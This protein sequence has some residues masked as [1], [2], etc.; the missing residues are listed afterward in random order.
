MSKDILIATQPG[1]FHAHAVAEALRRKGER[2]LL[3][4]T[5]DFPHRATETVRFTGQTR[6]VRIAGPGLDVLDAGD[7]RVGVVWY[8]RPDYV[9]DEDALHPADVGFADL[10]CDV[11]RLSLFQVLGQHAFWV[12]DPAA[13]RQNSKLVQHHAAV[14]VG[15]R[16]PDTL[17]S[18]D[19][20]AIRAFLR[21]Q[22]GRCVYKP[23]VA[24]SWWS[25]GDTYRTNYTTLIR[26]ADLVD[27]D[28][29]RAVPGIYQALVPKAHEL[30]VT[31]MGHEIVAVRLLSQQTQAGKLDWRKGKSELVMEPCTLPADLAERC[32]ALLGALGF[33]FGC[34]DFVVTP[35]GEHVFL[36]VNQAGQFL[37]VEDCTGRPVLDMFCEFLR[38][39]RPDFRWTE[40]ADPVR[41]AQVAP[42]AQLLL[43]EARAL[44]GPAA[45]YGFYEAPEASAEANTQAS[46]EAT[47]HA[48]AAS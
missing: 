35:A 20:H 1:D 3:W 28:L 9:V 47:P 21:E 37:F 29:L 17:Y 5:S 6:S 31:I 38:Q 4:H 11:F 25:D 41:L 19:P 16:M 24:R 26:E 23:L 14:A 30:R 18:N 13:V 15:L 10:S 48:A 40:H 27:D 36:E 8:R 34:L 22:G 33:I 12:N 44:H 2:P 32:I 46:A 39:R 7:Q 42:S 43:D 45:R